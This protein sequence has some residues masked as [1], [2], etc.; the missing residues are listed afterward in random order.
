[1]VPNTL[2]KDWAARKMRGKGIAGPPPLPAE[3]RSYQTIIRQVLK[4]A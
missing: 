2:L 1:M 4:G 3:V